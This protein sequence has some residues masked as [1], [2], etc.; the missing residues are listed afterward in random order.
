MR[1]GNQIED[2]YPLS[3][4]QHGMLFHSLFAPESGV[5]YVQKCCTLRGELNVAAF[6]Q[7]WQRVIDRHPILRTAFIWEELDQPLQVVYKQLSLPLEQNDWRRLAELDQ[8]QQLDALLKSERRRGF[9]LKTAPVM[10]LRLIRLADDHYQFIWTHHHLLLDGWCNT[11]ILKELFACYEAFRQGR[12]PVLEDCRP[13]RDYIVWLQSQD[14]AGAEKFWRETLAGFTTPTPLHVNTLKRPRGEQQSFSEEHTLLSLAATQALHALARK[15]GLTMHTIVQGAWALLLNRYSSETDV[16]FGDVVS[17]RPSELRGIEKMIGMFINVLPVRMKID[18]HETLIPWLKRLQDQ[19]IESRQYEYSP[20]SQI[21]QWSDVPQGTA[22]FD[23]LLSYQNYPVDASLRGGNGTVRIEEVNTIQMANYPITV[24]IT[25][26]PELMALIKYDC[27]LF[28]VD[29]IR[30]ML[31]HFKTLL[32]QIA[33]NSERQLSDYDLLPHAERQQLLVEWNDTRTPYPDRALIHELF[34]EQVQRT[35]DAAAI[36]FEGQTLTYRE[37]NERANQLAHYL[38]SFGIGSEVL[39]GVC[40]ERSVEM[41]VALLAILKA[42][43]AYVPLDSEYPLEHLSFMCDDAAPPLLLTTEKLADKL[44]A[45]LSQVIYVDS[46]AELI[47]QQPV[48]DLEP[49]LTS[50]NLAYVMYT[51]GSTGKHKGVSVTHRGVVRLVKNTSYADF[52]RATVFLQLAPISFDASTMEIWAPLLNGGQLVIMPPGVPALA[53]LGEAIRQYN[54]TTLWLTA[55]LF[56]LMVDERLDDLRSVRQLIAGGDVLS[57]PHVRKAVAALAA[58]RVTNG[59]GP[60][61]GTTFTCCYAATDEQQLHDTVPIGP[62]IANTEVYVLDQQLNPVPAGVP[63]ELYLGGAGLARGYLNQGGLTAERFIPHPH[64]SEPGA[65]LYKTGDRARWL[66]NGVLEFMGR[67]D[68]QVKLRGYRIEPGE[69]ETVLADCAGVRECVVVVRDD[70]GEKRLVAYVVPADSS[71]SAEPVREYLRSRLPDYMIPARFVFIETLPLTPNG[72]VNR[73]ALPAPDGTSDDATAT[74]VSPQTPTEE[75]LVNIWADVLQIERVGVCDSFFD[76]GGHSLLATQVMSR[77]RE[78]F[79]FELP[80]RELFDHPTVRELAQQL[81]AARRGENVVEPELVKTERSGA[82]PFSFA[83]QR[84]WF[85]DQLDPGNP[86]Y[87]IPFRLRLS[88][89]LNT[90]ALQTS[91]NELV[92][93]HETLRTSFALENGEPVQV[94]APF[95]P[96]T[97][98]VIDLSRLPAESAGHEIRALCDAELSNGFNLTE[99][100]LWRMRLLRLADNENLLLLTMHH[101]ISDA[102]SM[103]VL[104][105]EVAAFYNAYLNGE[106]AGLPELALTYAD[107]SVWQ[108]QYLSGDV[109][110][111]QL[112][113]WKKQLAGAPSVFQLASDRPRPALQSYRGAIV[114]F[115]CSVELSEALR[116]LAR[117]EGASLYMILLA[118]FAVLLQRFSGE[119]RMIIGTPIANRKRVEIEGLIGFFVNSLAM[120]VDMTGDP[121]FKELV[122][123]VREVVLGAYENQDVPFE[124]VVQEVAPQR[125][126]SRAPIFQVM[127][128][129]QNAPAQALEMQGL[130]ITHEDVQA[131]IAKYDLGLTMWE[132]EGDALIEGVL[133]YV[134]DLYDDSRIRRMSQHFTAFLESAIA[135]PEEHLS[136][137][138]KLPEIERLQLKEWNNTEALYPDQRCIHELFEDQVV[139]TP[140]ATGIICNGDEI[141]Y[142][143]LNSRANK[144]ARHLQK[145]GVMAETIVACCLRQS[146]E[147]LVTVLGI[148]KA[149]GAYL[150]L[151]P[152]NPT[153]RLSFLLDN[154][155][156]T[157]VVTEREFAEKFRARFEPV[158]YLDQIDLESESDQN[159][160]CDLSAENLAY[161]IYTSGSTGIPKGVAVQHRSLVNHSTAMAQQY[162]LKLGDRVLQF[163]SINFDVAAE[164][165]FP[166]WLSGA[167]V[168][169]WPDREHAS[170]K[171][172]ERL[173]ERCKVTVLNLPTPYWQEWVRDLAGRKASLS[174]KL[175]LMIV[176]SAAGLPEVFELWQQL[177]GERVRCVNA[178]GSTEATI[179]STVYEVGREH[180]C[181]HLQ[182]MPVGRPIANTHVYLLDHKLNQTPIGVPGELYLGGEG[183]A[184]GYLHDPVLTAE[185]FIP[186]PYSTQPGARLYRTGDRARYVHGGEIQFLGRLDEQIKLRGFRI[187]PAEIE[188]VLAQHPAVRDVIVVVL[189]D[190]AK[191]EYL[192]AYVVTDAERPSLSELRAHLRARLPEYMVPATFVFLEALPLN[193][194]GKVDR[195][196]LPASPISFRSA[197]EYVAP[198]TPPEEMLAS[199][200]ANVLGIEEPGVRESFFDLGGH[201]LLATQVV[202]RIRDLFGVEV[203]LRELF[204]EPT[205]EGLAQRLESAQQVAPRAAIAQRPRPAQIPLSYAQQRLWFLHQ[206]EPDSSF[207]N[208]A[209]ALRLEG[210]LNVVALGESLNDVVRRH[211]SLRTR[212]PLVDGQPVQLI[213]PQ[214]TIDLPVENTGDDLI[215]QLAETE[216]RRPFELANGPLL[217]VK[218]LRLDESQH[219]LLLTL[220]HIVADGWSMGVLV[221]EV[222]AYY[223]ERANGKIAGL[224]ELQIQYADFA[225]WQREFLSKDVLDQQLAYW[226]RQLEGAPAEIRLPYDRPRPEEQTYQG[227]TQHFGLSAEITKQLQALSR[228]EGVTLYMSLLAAFDVLLHWWGAGDDIV[229]GTDVANRN[230]VEV[231]GLIG[232]FVNQLTMRVDL[233]GEPTFR[234]LLERVRKV[235]LEAYAHQEVPFDRVVDAASRERTLK[236]S[237]LFQVKL[238]LENTPAAALE[239]PGLTLAPVEFKR[240]TAQ[241][242]LIVR[243]SE[244]EG[245]MLGSVEY[246]RDL[247]NDSTISHLLRRFEILL[248]E[249]PS[250]L[251][252]RLSEL[253]ALLSNQEMQ[254]VSTQQRELKRS[255]SSKLKGRRREAKQIVSGALPESAST[256]NDQISIN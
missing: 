240:G 129:W 252:M 46:E 140:D 5:Y 109:L 183:L 87:N 213:E 180:D 193:A 237:P 105:R 217:R 51:S 4:V 30:R 71:P 215:E 9:D 112:S 100:P 147:L 148:L 64:S 158:V 207:Y 3:P 171:D 126:L 189:S 60:T 110:Q 143:E 232:F 45:L 136:S 15:H 94:V 96:V 229:V 18:S 128:A 159:L 65:R 199:I 124:R 36:V 153:D 249:I 202:S 220:H 133:D 26:V 54:V 146:P 162:E 127:F 212:F 168:V 125:D 188:T 69:I 20:L 248:S 118:A 182:S 152:S 72:K 115:S 19:Q 247:F 190:V 77:I 196:A 25:P 52:D 131:G 98:T 13:F 211:E 155:E 231:E 39:V 114:P 88:G 84:L 233:S 7:A 221:K 73:R 113:Y 86:A 57:V 223:N 11:L 169:L 219:V 40:L 167:T 197:A 166:T 236:Y 242:D 116:M 24:T 192:A 205:I 80:L 121:T 66:T 93:R 130:K 41:M 48:N 61:E 35:P 55:G 2:L 74:Y 59:Y 179:T 181:K 200:W 90:E 102:W 89:V 22:L 243:L 216:A 141:S 95:S 17:G 1:N 227:V 154:A 241:F 78:A 172:L 44:P 33:A 49:E 144:L 228:S 187:E 214:L 201:S 58:G 50:D 83:Q 175:R 104:V 256:L 150:P 67:F 173:V 106:S 43:G 103:G 76:L 165:I 12:E 203:A 75:V 176:G 157:T 253:V 160:S 85:L 210:Q 6:E 161:A 142:R 79:G 120:R 145:Q 238:I 255:L 164:E 42:G 239:V 246:S 37:L 156:V 47:A 198:R 92:R 139:H 119:E 34:E 108:R 135:A 230:A 251:D 70:S 151:D 209:I 31:G 191:R 174:A 194:N 222:A 123:R 81:D 225:L 226:T 99:G 82:A 21:Q 63:G 163:A 132:R 53:D 206:M 178:Y 224:G 101:I 137:L 122:K 218:L 117:R 184:R 32:E 195:N 177:A 170:F 38:K 185:R 14:L 29:T 245:S 234:E 91:I 56:H 250:R 138:L 107:Y 111:Q 16:V 23:T 97:I 27:S 62:P 68:N 28:E 149:G 235:S 244:F 134:T 254:N 8:Q 208:V 204:E 10:K 186:D